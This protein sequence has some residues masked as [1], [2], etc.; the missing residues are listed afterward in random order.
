MG[1]GNETRESIIREAAILFNQKGYFGLSI[2]DI[3]RVTGL[4]KGGI[5][6]HFDS[7]DQLALE[8]FDYSVGVLRDTFLTAIEG[9]TTAFEK[10]A[11]IASVYQNAVDHPPLEGGCP[12]L[13][14][15]VESDDAHPALKEKAQLAMGKFLEMLNTIL[16]QGVVQGEF[17]EDINVHQLSIYI[18][19]IF[20]VC[21]STI[22][23]SGPRIYSAL[24]LRNDIT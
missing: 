19:S 12:L 4:Q 22:N 15:A 11:A 20:K 16:H 18:T 7:K 24:L 21:V 2:S 8:A 5:Y 17:N 10:L 14:T 23:C 6:N 3:S 9:K 13:N 1:K